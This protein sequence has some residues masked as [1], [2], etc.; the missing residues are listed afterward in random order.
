MA[1]NNATVSPILNCR[2]RKNEGT[3]RQKSRI[4]DKRYA[5]LT[6]TPSS[7][8]HFHINRNPDVQRQRIANH[9]QSSFIVL[10]AKS[11]G[12]CDHHSIG[13]PSSAYFRHSCKQTQCVCLNN[14]I[15]KS[16][17]ATTPTH[18]RRMCVL[19]FLKGFLPARCCGMCSAAARYAH[20]R[21]ERHLVMSIRNVSHVSR[22]A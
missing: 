19:T 4:K 9:F 13:V 8:S 7:G 1:K 5:P 21:L 15:L 22:P 11:Q 14:Q 20:P 10:D 3:R 6:Q 18:R 12:F 2:L 17:S 16:H